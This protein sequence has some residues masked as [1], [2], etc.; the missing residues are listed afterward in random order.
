MTALLPCPFCGGPA[1]ADWGGD[2]STAFEAGC[3]N[4]GCDISPYAWEADGEEAAIAAWNTRT[5]PAPDPLLAQMA[6]A[7]RVAIEQNYHDMIMTGEELR[8]C[9]AAL[10]AY[11]AR[12]KP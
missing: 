6:E 10:S 8:K 5:Q 1:S 9:S 11:D 12:R 7:L 2:H 3:Y 4:H